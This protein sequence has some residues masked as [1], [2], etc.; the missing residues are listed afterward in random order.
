MRQIQHT[1][2]SYSNSQ[3]SGQTGNFTDPY[4]GEGYENIVEKANSVPL[5]KIFK[6]YGIQLDEINRKTTCP[7]KS[8]KGGREHTASFYYY[9]ETNTYCCFGCRQGSKPVDFVA[10]M[11]RC[12]KIKASQKILERFHA[13]IDEEILYNKEDFQEKLQIM[14]Q[15]SDSVRNFRKQF[16]DD[17]SYLFIEENCKVF[18]TINKKHGLTN[19]A[20]KLVVNKLIDAINNYIP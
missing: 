5:S 10:N 3:A 2:R 17:K 4:A 11:E 9:S 15:Y 19:E 16:I 1:N 8:H 12:D 20:L 6:Y 18:D 14:M 7:F 13:N